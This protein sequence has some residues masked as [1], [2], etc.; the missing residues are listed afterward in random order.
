[1]TMH[2]SIDT[3]QMLL[4]KE[5]LLLDTLDMCKQKAKESPTFPE[6]VAYLTVITFIES[7]LP[8]VQ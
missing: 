7:N 2:E 4:D 1:M 3:I 5:K 8:A 6:K